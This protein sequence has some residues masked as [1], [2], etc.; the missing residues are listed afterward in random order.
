MPNFTISELATIALVI[1]IVFGPQR[2]P[3]MAQKAG[4]LVRKGRTMV[5]DL[6][7][8]FEGEF[9]DVTEPLKEVRQEILGM[10]DEVESSMSSLTDD[11]AKAKEELEA[12]MAEAKKEIEDT[13]GATNKELQETLAEPEGGEDSPPPDDPSGSSGDDDGAQT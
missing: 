5:N 3:E 4:Q 10:K 13:V 9:S 12:Q 7:R 1:L 11:V 2:L 6:R 8:E